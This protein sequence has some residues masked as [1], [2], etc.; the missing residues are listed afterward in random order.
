MVEV[1]KPLRR[2]LL[3]TLAMLVAAVLIGHIAKGRYERHSKTKQ[4]EA[5]VAR[6]TKRLVFSLRSQNRQAIRHVDEFRGLM[7]MKSVGRFDK[8][9]QLDEFEVSLIP[10]ADQIERYV[11]AAQVS[12]E[13]P[14]AQALE[15]H[16]VF[17]HR[18]SF[19]AKPRHELMLLSMLNAISDD[20]DTLRT[21]ER[22]QLSRSGE[23]GSSTL[24]T[25]CTVHWYSFAPKEDGA[26][27]P[28]SVPMVPAAP[29]MPAASAA[30]S[31]QVRR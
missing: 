28:G 27:A 24:S 9:W 15:Q 23:A 21:I 2:A 13:V 7:R 18:L 16:A 11:L 3:L 12:A 5:Q 1:L 14:G 6:D 30:A 25:R 4:H 26:G 17:A 29:V 20:S 10:Y 8:A 31:S 22:C 19:E